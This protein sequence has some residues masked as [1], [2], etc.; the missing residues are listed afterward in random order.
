[1][2]QAKTEEQKTRIK[3]ILGATSTWEGGDDGIYI[4]D[5]VSYDEMASVVDYLRNGDAT[6]KDELF[7]KCWVAYRRKG[8]KKK[9]RYY[10]D[11]L[12][13]KERDEILPHIKVYVTTRELIYQR[14][15]ERYLRDKIFNDVIISGSNNIAYDPSKNSSG[16]YH[17][18]TDGFIHWNDF[19]NCYIY[20][21]MFITD[22][23]DGYTD[24]DR[25]DGATLMLNNARGTIKWNGNNKKWEKL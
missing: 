22:I 16:E 5:W 24:D 13:Q 6:K 15:F 8:S 14:D 23:V 25:P 10:W 4:D 19:Y 1:M 20:V 3:E 2:L 17:P 12:T 9:A 7:E 18:H 11:K 21:G